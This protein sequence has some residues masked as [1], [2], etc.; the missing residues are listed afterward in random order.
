MRLGLLRK[1]FRLE[2]RIATGYSLRFACWLIS[3]SHNL[4]RKATGAENFT[5]GVLRR[6]SFAGSRQNRHHP[7][8][9]EYRLNVVTHISAELISLG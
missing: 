9:L 7:D 1:T 8:F 4:D 5:L 2:A 6:H 3:A